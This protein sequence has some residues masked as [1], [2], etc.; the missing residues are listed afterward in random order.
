[1]TAIRAAPPLSSL[2]F[3]PSFG[4]GLTFFFVPAFLPV[5][6]LGAGTP[7][8]L[9]RGLAVGWGIEGNHVFSL[10]LSPP[11]GFCFPGSLDF[12]FPVHC[13]FF[14]NPRSMLLGWHRYKGPAS[15]RKSLSRPLTRLT[16]SEC[17]KKYPQKLQRGV[18]LRWAGPSVWHVCRLNPLAPGVYSLHGEKSI[19]SYCFH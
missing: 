15:Q 6:P 1:M 12:F 9:L 8:C 14:S 5:T 2:L 19:K 11:P 10:F 16:I 13:S 3:P 17:W 7:C 18:L 4:R